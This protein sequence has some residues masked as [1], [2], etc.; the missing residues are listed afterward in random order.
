MQTMELVLGGYQDI[1][2]YVNAD[3]VKFDAIDDHIT[4]TQDHTQKAVENVVVV[5][6]LPLSRH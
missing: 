1:H 5:R 3:D 2:D 4:T 6:A